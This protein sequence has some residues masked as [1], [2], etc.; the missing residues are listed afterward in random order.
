MRFEIDDSAAKIKD[1][2]IEKITK[3]FLKE[4]FPDRF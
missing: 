1:S 3:D 4:K 2:N